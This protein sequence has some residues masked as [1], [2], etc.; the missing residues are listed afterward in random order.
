MHTRLFPEWLDSLCQSWGRLP[1]YKASPTVLAPTHHGVRGQDDT[2]VDAVLVSYPTDATVVYSS[3]SVGSPHATHRLSQGG[4]WRI[5]LLDGLTRS[6]CLSGLVTIPA[7][8]CRAATKV[9][10]LHSIFALGALM[11]EWLTECAG[12]PRC[13]TYSIRGHVPV[14]VGVQVQ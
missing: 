3:I 1:T 4:G 2:F 14:D 7:T 13:V 11:R 8:R 6:S 12:L 10:L 5:Q 9:G